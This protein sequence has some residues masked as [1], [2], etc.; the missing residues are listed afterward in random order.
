MPITTA[1][2]TATKICFSNWIVELYQGALL[3]QSVTT[4]TNGHYEF[5]NVTPGS[6]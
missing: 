4:D 5:D 6:G 2:A 1:R 3:L